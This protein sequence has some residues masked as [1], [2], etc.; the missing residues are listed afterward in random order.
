VT[1]DGYKSFEMKFAVL[2]GGSATEAVTLE[3]GEAA[4][5]AVTPPPTPGATPAPGPAPAPGAQPATTAPATAEVSTTG[6][7]SILPWVAF[8][9]GGAGLI[10]GGIA[11]IAALSDHS[12]IAKDCPGGTCPADNPHTSDISAYHTMGTLSTVGFIVAGV[13]AAA[14]VVLLVTQ[15]KGSGDSAP[16]SSAPAPATG[17]RLYPVVGV[18]SAGVLGTF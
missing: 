11:G 3:K 7:K 16:P 9:V 4:A 6:K 2:E 13:G 10:L 12:S 1:A 15:P 18:G 5:P 17:V 8:G 14:G